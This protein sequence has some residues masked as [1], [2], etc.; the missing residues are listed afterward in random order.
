[1]KHNRFSHRHY[2][3]TSLVLMA[4]VGTSVAVTLQHNHTDAAPTPKKAA[5]TV[6]PSQFSFNATAASDWTKGPSN[7]TSM[8]L[9]Y[10]PADCF[11]SVEYKP[12]TVDIPAELAKKQN[13]MNGDGYTSTPGAIVSATLQTG[14][15]P[16]TYQLHQFAVSG[17]GTDKL[18]PADEFGYLPLAHG[19]I[20]VEAYCTTA[21]N[22]AATIPALQAITFSQSDWDKSLDTLQS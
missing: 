17:G 12:G 10:K 20:K 15:G 11:T 8:A 14:S 22:L 9:F 16:Q 3:T 1:M 21:Q 7:R 5:S 6:H 13:M 19:Y 18:Y 4:I 2:I